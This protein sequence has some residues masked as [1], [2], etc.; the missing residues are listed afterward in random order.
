MHEHV[1]R[2]MSCG[3][4]DG[5]GKEARFISAR[6]V[7]RITARMIFGARGVHDMC[8]SSRMSRGMCTAEIAVGIELSDELDF[9]E[10]IRFASKSVVQGSCMPSE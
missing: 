8:N 10:A 3:L 7:T 4:Q 2:R 6:I 9:F 5:I 1:F